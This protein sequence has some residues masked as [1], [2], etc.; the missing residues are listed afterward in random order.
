VMREQS[1]YGHGKVLLTGEYFILDGARALALPTQLGQKLNV[2]FRQSSDPKL[3]W[4][5]FDSNGVCWYEAT[6]EFWHF[7]CLDNDST[8]TQILQTL[9]RQA[10]KQNVHFLRD[11]VDIFV[12]TQLE[13]PL[14]WG[15]G[16]SSTLVYNIAQWAYVSPFEL[17]QK[18]LGGSGYDIACAQSLGPITYEL[19]NNGPRWE[20]QNFN[21]LFKDN[22]YFVYLNQKQDTQ[23]SISHYRNLN[24]VEKEKIIDQINNITEK[25]LSCLS[26]KEFEDLVFEHENLL[27]MSL[28]LSRAY[29]KYF[30]DY[31][32]AIKSLGAWGGDFVLATSDMGEAMT[33]DYF[34]RRG[35]ETVIPY[36]Q[37]ISCGEETFNNAINFMPREFNEISTLRH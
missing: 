24:V 4:K 21:P 13:F 10:R 27:S 32:G 31:W 14:S 22:L 17:L 36:Q 11:E 37:L 7:N 29:D 30:Q 26:L 8:E 20:K 23:Q 19:K 25:M 12:E 16:S 35:F 34:K 33:L 3:F 28:G 6:F 5:S 1:F 15:L 2:K 9:L 18:T